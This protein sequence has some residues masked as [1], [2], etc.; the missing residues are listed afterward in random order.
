MYRGNFEVAAL[1]G[2]RLVHYFLSNQDR[3]YFSEQYRPNE[4]NVS[5]PYP[6]EDVD[7][8]YTGAYSIYN[9]E[10]FFH[11]PLLIAEKLCTNQRYDEALTWIK[12]ILNVTIDSLNEAPPGR[13]WR[14][15]PFKH[16]TQESV[17]SMMTR[18][19]AGDPDLLAQVADWVNHPFEPFRIAR[20]R[21]SAFMKNVLMKFWD[22]CIGCG[23]YLFSQNTIESIN[24]AEQFYV[25]VADSQ[26][27]RPLA[28]PA[29]GVAA[30]ENYLKLKDKLD[31]FSN[32]MVQ[33]ENAFPFSG[34]LPSDPTADSGGLL[35][36]SDTLYFCI[37]QNATLLSYWD[38]VADRLSKIRN[39]MNIQGVRQQLPLFEPILDPALL[40]EAAA[41]GVDVGSVLS[42]LNSP[43][44]YYRFSYILQKAL[45][46][47]SEC[48]ALGSALLSA[49]EKSD[50]EALSVLR[51][52]QE[53]QVQG[54]MKQ[55]KQWQ[56]DAA[57]ADVTALQTSRDSAAARYVAYQT[58][59]TGTAPGAPA[60]GAG[61]PLLS[62]PTQP[63]VTTDSSSLLKEEQSAL[64]SSHSARDWKVR[65]STME[66]LAS[67]SHYI[68]QFH[69]HVDFWGLG[70][71]IQFGG[72]HVGPAL[73]AIARYQQ[74]LSDQDSYDAS[75]ADAMARFFRRQQD[76]VIQSN[77]AAG[78]IMHIDKQ[79][80]AANVRSAVAYYDLNSLY[81]A[82]QQNAQAV[83]DFLT[84]KQTNQALYSWV[85]SD[86]SSTYFQCYK[87]AYDL[88]KQAERTYRFERGVVDS[89]FI[90]FGYW[91]SLHKGLQSGERL[92]LA[93]K[94][95]E[96]AYQDQNK[97][98]Y[99]IVKYVSLELLDPLALISL[100][101]TG[102]CMVNLPELFFDMDYPGHYMRRIKTVSLTISAVTGPYTSVNCT[103][104]LLKSKIRFD[105]NPQPSYPEQDQDPRFIYNF[106]ATQSIATSTAQSDA[107]LFEVQFRDERYLPF[108][109]AGLIS[110]WR[111][112]M[113]KENNAF[114][115][116]SVVHVGLKFFY[117]SRFGGDPLRQAARKSPDL[118]DDEPVRMFSLKHEFAAVWYQFL[119]P[120]DSADGHSVTLNLMIE[121]FPYAYRGKLIAIDKVEAFL[122]FRDVYDRSAFKLDP[123]T[124]SPLGDYAKG[125]SLNLR[126]TPPG[127]TEVD[128][129]I[130]CDSLFGGAPHGVF[131][132]SGQ[133]GDLGAWLLH[134]SDAD[135]LAL[136]ASLR[137]TV[138]SSGTT[139]QRLVPALI[140][141]LIVVCHYSF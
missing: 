51:A 1:E 89:N 25:L 30:P 116:E 109:G 97:R 131:D 14:F 40:V 82:Q 55:L 48:R 6:V 66:T 9:W 130:K 19:D 34:G 20:L 11:A 86:V 134:V 36:M 54:L 59:I 62:V 57:T 47:T 60:A 125:T 28:L 39:C 99:E 100:K 53:T 102:Q 96:R 124:P 26:G 79:I 114:D 78:E 15:T 27:D 10:I 98:D 52:T 50:A 105:S 42:D 22:I 64:D 91:D 5:D 38:T 94:Q 35:G 4:N 72:Q 31:A 16:V 85:I 126:L 76:W 83:Q 45:D 63:I 61:I 107:G 17:I 24:L 136:P 46:M 7:F 77:A 104:T 120:V 140:S 29:R 133:P 73:S 93:L 81:P 58:L 75:H 127:G 110:Q 44:P 68:P 56:Y 23:D 106:A 87:L 74:N 113:P 13:Y 112:E 33:V 43:L 139:H 65:A 103:L 70:I 92:Y 71:E 3:F 128:A 135:V 32:A 101:E 111:L 2:N 95:M 18:L 123:Q 67:L 41:Q 137:T 69:A 117:T 132:L 12:Y 108:E 121:R 115:F 118:P 49:L 21:P 141:D 84:G 8:R 90:Q 37:P 122:I 119:R 88:G 129:A 138:T 80:A